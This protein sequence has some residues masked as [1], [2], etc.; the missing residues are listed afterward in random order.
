MQY[1]LKVFET[2]DRINFRTI[3]RDGEPWFV[4]ADVCQALDIAN[5]PSRP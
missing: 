2:E 5:V 1:A 3:N 4:L